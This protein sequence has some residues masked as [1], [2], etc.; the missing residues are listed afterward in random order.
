MPY[1]PADGLGRPS[2]RLRLLAFLMIPILVLMLLTAALTYELALRYINRLHDRDLAGDAR[3]LASLLQAQ[4]LRGTLSPQSQALLAFSIDGGYYSVRSRKRGVLGG[5]IRLPRLDQPAPG[6]PPVLADTSVGASPL[7]TASVTLRAPSDPD[8]AVTVTIGES[9][10]DRWLTAR[11]V[12]LIATPLQ[13]A[14]IACL[15]VLVWLGVG[16]GLRSLHPL[17]RELDARGRGLNPITNAM[18]P[19]EILPLT[20]T[21]DAAFARL[22]EAVAVQE[23]FVA[24]AAHQLRTPLSGLR[25][26]VERA[27]QDPRPETVR[28][29]LGHV[30]HLTAQT[31][32]TATQLLALTRAQS[33]F[34]PFERSATVVITSLAPQVVASR[35]HHAIRAG[36]DLGYEGSDQ[37]IRV[38]GETAALHELLDNLVD[39]AVR[40]AGDGS[41]V[42]VAV[43]PPADGAATLVVEDDGPGVPEALWPRLGERFFRVPESGNS[44]TGLGLAIVR[45]IA[46]RHGAALLFGRGVMGGL[47]ISVALPLQAADS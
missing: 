32:R 45:R 5:N 33:P 9:V 1:D 25:L 30:A 28:D 29:A 37:E 18:V 35:V 31:S 23:R 15:L 27:L 11:E 38:L 24:D 17:M 20:R 7:R 14:V 13:A 22:R 3:S 47:R 40:Y 19:Q 16:A 10:R 26:H 41:T 36:V 44:G 4:H 2:L 8:D 42:T 43:L 6:A 21:I 12:L 46:Q 34:E 39:N